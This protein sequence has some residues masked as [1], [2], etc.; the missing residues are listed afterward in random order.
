MSRNKYTTPFHRPESGKTKAHDGKQEALVLRGCAEHNLKKV[1]LDIPHDIL[2][3]L[4]GVSGSGK[5]SLA[6]ETIY[7]EGQRRYLETFSPYVRQFFERFNPAKVDSIEHLRPT[8]A[9]QQKTRV[10]SSRSTVGTLTH[11]N[12]LLKVLWANI[13]DPTCGTCG[14][15][16]EHWQSG[17]L[18]DHVQSTFLVRNRSE[19]II[20]APVCFDKQW[21]AAVERLQILGI[22][23]Y[24]EVQSELII[25][26]ED[27]LARKK[28]PTENFIL[29]ISRVRGNV[30]RQELSDAIAQS[31]KFGAHRCC[32]VERVPNKR[33]IGSGR[34]ISKYVVHIFT[35]VPQCPTPNGEVAVRKYAVPKPALFTFNHPYGACPACNGFGAELVIDYGKCLPDQ[36]LSIEEGAIACWSTPGT[37]WER[38]QLF[39]FCHKKKISITTPWKQL[40]DDHRQLVLYGK[41]KGFWG[42]QSWFDWLESKKYKMHIRVLLSKY[43][44]QVTCR[45]CQGKRLQPDALAYKCGGLAL[46]DLW[47]MTVDR[48]SPWLINQRNLL[49][50]A[51]KL[52]RPIRELFNEIITRLRYLDDLG[53]SYLTLERSARTLSGGETQRV[54]LANALGGSL[55]STHFILDEPSVGL[56]RKDSKQLVKSIRGLQERGNSVLMVEHDH[57][58]LHSAD[59][60]IE[61]GPEAG[62]QGGKVVYNGSAAAHPGSSKLLIDVADSAGRSDLKKVPSSSGESN[63]IEVIGASANNIVDLSLTI[64]LRSL[65][66]LTGV[67]GSGKSTLM[68]SIIYEGFLKESSSTVVPAFIKKCAVVDQTPLVKSPRATIATYT[69]VWDTMRILFANSEDA[70]ARKIK[71]AHF[72]FNVP[73]GR[74]ESCKGSGA[75]LEEMQFLGDVTI[76]CDVCGGQRYKPQILEVNFRG[77]TVISWLRATVNEAVDTLADIKPVVQKLQYLQ[78]VGLGHLTLGH[79]L[80]DLSGGEAQRL[81]LV[82]VLEGHEAEETLLLFDEP[83][84]GLEIRDVLKLIRL[85]HRLRERGCSIICIAHHCALM[86]R[87]DWLIDLG[88]DGGR[89]GGRVVDQGPPQEVETRAKGYTGLAMQEYRTLVESMKPGS[90]PLTQKAVRKKKEADCVALAR[91]RLVE[92]RF[93][94]IKGAREHNLRNVSVDLPLGSM[95]GLVGVSGSGKSTVAKDIVHAESQHQFLSCLSPYAR[96][97]VNTLSRPD[98]D[99]IS[100]L[101]P[102]IFVGQHQ[103]Q[104][105]LLSTVGTISEINHYL[106]LLFAK[107]GQQFCTEHPDVYVGGGSSST[108]SD[109]LVEIRGAKIVRLLAPIIRKKKGAHREVFLRAI[110]LGIDEVRCDGVFGAPSKFIDDLDKRIV[111][112]IEYV[113]LKG[114]PQ[115]LNRDLLTEAATW[116]ISLG[117]GEV[118][119]DQ[120]NGERSEL[121]SVHRSCPKCNRGYPKLDPEDFSFSSRRGRCV[122]CSGTGVGKNGK[123]C[124]KC[125]GTRLH[126]IARHVKISGYTISDLCLMHPSRLISF[127]DSLRGENVRNE[128]IDTLVIGASARL[129]TLESL[130]LD[131]LSLSREGPTLSGGELQRLR[132]AA[133]LASP[134]TGMMYIF[135]EPSIGL[136]PYDAEKVLIELRRLCEAGNSIVMIEHDADCIRSCDHIIEIGPGGGKDG[137]EVVF[138][139]PG[140]KFLNGAPTVTSKMIAALDSL[141]PYS[142]REIKSDD[143]LRVINGKRN[144]ISDL[145]L[146]VPLGA[147]TTVVG[148]S[149]SGK[150]SLVQGLIVAL[151]TEGK[152]RESKDGKFSFEGVYGRMVSDRPIPKVVCVDQ[153]PIGLNSRS[154]P[155]SFLGIW[156]PIRQIFAQSIQAKSLGWNAGYFSYNTGNGRCREC[157]GQGELQLEMSFL[158]NARVECPTCRGTRYQDD[159]GEV[160]YLGKSIV[161]ILAMTFDEARNF[162]VN[163]RKILPILSKVCELGL[164]YLTLGQPAPS[165]SG[166][167]SQRLKLVLE[168]SRKNVEGVLFVFDEPTVGLHLADVSKLLGALR[169]LVSNR[170]TVIVVEH[171]VQ[172]VLASDYIVEMGPGAGVAG[173]KVVFSGTLED[174]YSSKSTWGEL[175]CQRVRS[176]RRQIG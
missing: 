141:S 137:G 73:G 155:I 14:I 134:L 136:H 32:I 37:E 75:V 36:S 7:A 77:R 115:R 46:P 91:N 45:V 50:E 158:P 21:K 43:K 31:F 85:L 119:I 161:E 99:A 26:A 113:V 167:E 87:S 157:R 11:L 72:S 110:E 2:V 156:D 17:L 23:R 160:K 6:F 74:C 69:K 57:F 58:L 127:L 145:S 63:F 131:Y 51:G 67:S 66:C 169:E 41:E 81:K 144:N 124:S 118:I 22:E 126:D 102:T 90:K 3:G 29:V 47:S 30:D 153:K 54:N 108:V 61:L 140:E 163:H 139:G 40:P 49:G 159:V 39:S 117:E 94:S 123:E 4:T 55:V 24:F 175:V 12:D 33:G 16:L 93:L 125:Q 53:L 116:G 84:L 174:L 98:I 52:S 150:T 28:I 132:L 86:M 138:N 89:D 148:L 95:V 8:L 109:R 19:L 128:L 20:G 106:R 65:V 146:N 135:D 25:N 152:C 147:L 120:N 130:G 10:R 143:V 103:V 44:M 15:S 35:E 82:S 92:R 114:R 176:K 173:G 151:L 107:I 1:D 166:G 79:S 96:Q 154:T 171:E 13:S 64:P 129:R 78:E 122:G 101:Q 62:E 133:A 104:P 88:P 56:H 27:L 60:I 168:L 80:A 34:A 100:G 9:I 164:G 112:T 59:Q 165:L 68:H 121:F 97:F 111:H 83:T 48:L 38:N 5:S 170:A 18:A 76:P 172:V 42:L 149:G 71:P 70:V 142:G 162:F 105:S